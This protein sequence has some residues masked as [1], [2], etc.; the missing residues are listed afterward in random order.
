LHARAILSE[1]V[2]DYSVLFAE[3]ADAYFEREMYAEA[4]PIYELLGGDPAVCSKNFSLKSTI[5]YL[6][7]LDYR[8]V[9]Y[10]F[11]FKQQHA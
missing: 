2:L 6:N 5:Q 1:E 9:A 4:K 11:F 8:P 3:I 10:I 7:Q